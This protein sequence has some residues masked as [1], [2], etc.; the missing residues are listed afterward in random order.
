MYYQNTSLNF[1]E[2]NCKS[3]TIFNNRLV[4]TAIAILSQ[5]LYFLNFCGRWGCLLDK[6]LPDRET[7]TVDADMGVPVRYGASGDKGDT[8][9]GCASLVQAARLVGQE[10]ISLVNSGRAT[11]Q[12]S[13]TGL[14]AR[15]N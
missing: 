13:F 11:Y 5:R 10:A 14:R 15:Y 9:M 6:F 7:D 12:H 3:I 8:N 4:N 2:I 1:F